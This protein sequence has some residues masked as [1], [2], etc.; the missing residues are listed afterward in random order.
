VEAIAEQA[1]RISRI[2]RAFLGLARG[3][4]PALEHVQPKILADVARELVEHRFAKASVT[5]AVHVDDALPDVAC[6]PKLF[7]QVLVNLLLNACDACK[8]GGHV[9]LAIR[10]EGG[11]VTFEVTDDGV[12]IAADTA[13]KAVE[14][15]F[16][17][18]DVDQGTGLGLA[19]ANEIVKHH[20]GT[21]RLAPRAG[22]AGTT[23]TVE[24]DAIPETNAHA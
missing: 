19:I 20:R 8:A 3:A 10:A 5:L 23:A 7:E 15:F 11:K 1:A 18:K 13:A 4:A 17:T 2:V 22:R 9:D 14:P 24:I 16:T 6:D 12:G 21:L